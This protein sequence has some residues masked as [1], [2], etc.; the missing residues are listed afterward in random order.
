MMAIIR[1][2]D[3]VAVEQNNQL[4]CSECWDGNTASS[5]YTR[6]DIENDTDNTYICDKCGKEC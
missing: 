3:I 4:L 2:E 6:E 1:N 5:Y